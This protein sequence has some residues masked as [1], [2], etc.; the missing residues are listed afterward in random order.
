VGVDE[1][2]ECALHQ[3]WP[4]AAKGAFTLSNKVTRFMMLDEF[5]WR[6]FHKFA[7]SKLVD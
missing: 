2:F 1:K 7:L 6:V 4:F 3:K 5:S